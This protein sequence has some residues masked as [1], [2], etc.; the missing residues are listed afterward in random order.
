MALEQAT[1]SFLIGTGAAATTVAVTG[2]GFTPK[3]ILFWWNGRTSGSDA[4]G[5]LSLNRGFGVA[6]SATDRFAVS[7]RSGDALATS[8]GR[9]GHSST[10]CILSQAS[11]IDGAADL[12]SMD[13]DGFTLEIDDAFPADLRIHYLALGG[14]DITHAKTSSFAQT[15]TAAPTTQA[16]TGIGFQPDALLFVSAMIN[17][18]A[19]TS[20][21]T[22]SFM[23]GAATASGS[24]ST[25]QAHYTGSSHAPAATTVT[26]GSARRTEVIAT[27]NGA[28][29]AL[30]N[31]GYLN[32]FQ[33]DGF[34]L[35]WNETGSNPG[36]IHHVLAL[37]G[38]ASFMV[39]STTTR[40]D[41]TPW[42]VT[43]LG[44]EPSAAL[45]VSRGSENADADEVFTHEVLSLGAA[46]GASARS[47]IGTFDRSALADSET[48]SA[49]E[50][51][52]VYARLDTTHAVTGLMD[53]QSFDS[54]GL[55]LVMDDADPAPYLV[56]FLA[57]GGGTT[58]TTPTITDV[59][60]NT[61]ELAGGTAITI[62]GTNFDTASVTVGGVAATSVVT[63]N[64]T[65]ITAVTPAGSAGAADVVVTNSDL[66]TDT[67]VGGFTYEDVPI[68]AVL[69]QTTDP[70]AQTSLTDIVVTGTTAG[71]SLIV[72]VVQY[73]SALGRDYV[74]TDDVNGTYLQLLKYNPDRAVFLYVKH[75]IAGGDITITGTR[76]SGGVVNGFTI[77]WEVSGLDALAD[78]IMGT[79]KDGANTTTHP[80][81]S[82]L[83]TTTAA[84][85]VTA[86]GLTGTL[87]TRTPATDYTADGLPT[88]TYFQHQVADDPLAS[89]TAAFGTGSSRIA[90]SLHAAFPVG[91]T[92]PTPAAD[93]AYVTWW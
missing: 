21:D 23:L 84:F 12:Q 67:L 33:S 81:S 15:T 36:H 88:Q 78:P 31:R 46:T 14:S 30:L 65:T 9:S 35:G 5:R 54:D 26:R 56:W 70:V 19:P 93:D 85:L 47:A 91:A 82:G 79:A 32:A 20:A 39:G 72:A 11:S 59:T 77:V 62:T 42:S 49:T 3:A 29:T 69:L 16:I 50:F 43:G 25:E 74:F 83:T 40:T 34:Q 27:F 61:G 58:P 10:A 48:S 37:K 22:S 73:D 86:S 7:S 45:F 52:A 44:F 51:D 60:P 41:T 1:G 13:G 4:A 75:G 18:A 68:E 89:H 53:L 90:V 55:T 17:A 6:V 71:A 28:R 63:V 8:D 2:L 57:V 76:T 66:E 92:T 24:S 87:G 38:T 80:C 64:A